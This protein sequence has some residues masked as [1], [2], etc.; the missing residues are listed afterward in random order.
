VLAPSQPLPRLRKKWG[1]SKSEGQAVWQQQV[2]GEDTRTD[3]HC[4]RAVSR[5]RSRNLKQQ[6]T[7]AGARGPAWD[8]SM[9]MLAG[10]I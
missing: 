8:W 1:A 5:N 6:R 4:D 7:S 3:Q 2:P 9:Q 10:S